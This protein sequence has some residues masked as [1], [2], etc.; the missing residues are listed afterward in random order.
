M[1]ILIYKNQHNADKQNLEKKF[2]DDD[3]KV[4]GISGLVKITVLNT[5]Y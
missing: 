2:G 3:K 1:T 4:P 5:K